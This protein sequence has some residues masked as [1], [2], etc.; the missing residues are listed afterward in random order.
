MISRGYCILYHS[1]YRVNVRMLTHKETVWLRGSLTFL[2]P[3]SLNGA[4]KF[5]LPAHICPSSYITV[6]TAT[7][8]YALSIPRDLLLPFFSATFY[9]FHR[10]TKVILPFLL[11]LCLRLLTKITIARERTCHDSQIMRVRFLLIYN[12]LLEKKTE[13]WCVIVNIAYH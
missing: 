11:A 3:S 5:L 4:N 12:K 7:W 13:K 9:H 6:K 1:L 8:Y 2:S 10:Q